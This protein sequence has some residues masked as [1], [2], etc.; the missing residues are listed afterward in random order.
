[1]SHE[2][3]LGSRGQGKRKWQGSGDLDR[4]FDSLDR[5]H[6]IVEITSAIGSGIVFD[7]SPHRTRVCHLADRLGHLFRCMSVTVFRIHTY[8]YPNRTDNP[9]GFLHSR[10][11]SE[12]SFRIGEPHTEGDTCAGGT[13]CGETR[14]LQHASATSVPRIWHHKNV[15][16]RMQLFEHLPFFCLRF[17]HDLIPTC[18]KAGQSASYASQTDEIPSCRKAGAKGPCRLVCG[19]RHIEKIHES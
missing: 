13:D 8:R 19:N 4:R 2:I 12:Q 1:M 17:T 6:S 11:P 16:G 9:T 15:V 3:T 14:F 5:Q 10:F 18:R 7:T